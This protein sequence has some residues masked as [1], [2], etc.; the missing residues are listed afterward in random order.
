MREFAP[1]DVREQPLRDMEWARAPEVR[2]GV[3]PVVADLCYTAQFLFSRGLTLN[4]KAQERFLDCVLDNYLPALAQLERRARGDYARDELPDTFPKFAP[5]GRKRD[6]GLSPEEL[7]EAWRKSRK[8]AHSTIESWQVVF[9]ALAL[10]FP[11]RSAASIRADEAQ[12]WLDDLITEERSAFTVRNTWLRAVRTVYTWAARR[13]LTGNPFA[14][15][16]VDVPRRKQLRPKSLYADEQKAILKAAY[17]VKTISNPDEASRRWVPWLLA[18]TGARPGEITQLWGRN[19]EQV[20]GIWTLNL[21]PEAGTIKGGRARRVPLH[22]HLVE[23]GFLNFAETHG[24]AP[25]FY[26]PRRQQSESGERKSPAAQ[27]RQR[28]A[29]WVRS[30]GIEEKGLSPNHGWR[31]TFKQIGRRAGLD[32]NMLDYICGHAPATVGRSYG[33]PTLRDMA[34]EIERFPR[35]DFAREEEG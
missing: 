35:Y 31:H 4:R 7:F 20:D 34:T 28:L 13:K 2:A 9:R 33:E 32:D 23:Q 29:A 6:V 5:Q 16:V 11:D 10:R 8:P 30:L 14:E 21:T 15:T 24:A 17:G 22:P 1:D 19:V 26:R 12:Q 27:A 3:R 18:Y 25:L